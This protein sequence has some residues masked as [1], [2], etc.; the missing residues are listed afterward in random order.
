MTEKSIFL[1]LISKIGMAK[2]VSMDSAYELLINRAKKYIKTWNI[3]H[4]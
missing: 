4:F 2:N 3:K 1:P